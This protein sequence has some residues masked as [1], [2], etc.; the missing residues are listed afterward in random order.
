MP[1]FLWLPDGKINTRRLALRKSLG[2]T[3]LIDSHFQNQ[4]FPIT[5]AGKYIHIKGLGMDICHL[6]TNTCIVTHA[7]FTQASLVFVHCSV[8]HIGN[9]STPCPMVT[10]A[11][12]SFR[13][14][15][16]FFT[17][18]LYITPSRVF[19]EKGRLLLKC[20][21]YHFNLT[22]S[23]FISHTIPRPN[24]HHLLPLAY[25]TLLTCLLHVYHL[26]KAFLS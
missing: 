15:L 4:C 5:E 17:S 19:Q 11:L 8:F 9:L 25:H 6:K 23:S 1:W 16:C 3:G 18:T 2:E 21:F 14:S 7:S 24:R 22:N 20:L 12:S 13:F 10:K 26:E